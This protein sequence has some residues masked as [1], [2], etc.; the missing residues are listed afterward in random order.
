M[1]LCTQKPSADVVTTRIKSNLPSAISF[2]LKAQSDYRT[3]FGKGIPYHLLGKGDGVCMIEG[4]AKEFVRFQSPVISLDMDEEQ[5]AYEKA[6]GLYEGVESEFSLDVAEP[7]EPIDKLK[8]II[9]DT[10]HTKVTELQKHMQ[11]RINVV[12]ELM[13]ELVEEGWLI[14][15]GKGYKLVVSEDELIN[16]RS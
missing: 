9:A 3:V 7:E 12:S 14:K 5:E 16:W 4:N 8:R 1:I 10:G 6:R 2:R 13:K 11:M 15:E